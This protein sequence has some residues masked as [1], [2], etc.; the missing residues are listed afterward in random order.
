MVKV[1]LGGNY[2]KAA[3]VKDGEVVMFL[4]EGRVETSDKYTYDDGNPQKYFVMTVDYKGEKKNIKI[5]AS[6]KSSL[7]EAWGD[8][9]QN[10]IGKKATILVIPVQNNNKSILLKPVTGG[11][12]DVEWEP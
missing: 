3:N 9:T 1:S 8:E 10:W 11:P 5:T 12:A 7:I 6:S 4:D 2:L